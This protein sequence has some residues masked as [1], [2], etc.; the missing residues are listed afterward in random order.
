MTLQDS[1][2]KKNYANKH[3]DSKKESFLLSIDKRGTSN[4]VMPNYP[5]RKEVEQKQKEI[6]EYKRKT[7]E[8]RDEEKVKIKSVPKPIVDVEKVKTAIEKAKEKEKD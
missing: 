7:A 1:N 8:T 6:K 3:S 2:A 5:T 4:I